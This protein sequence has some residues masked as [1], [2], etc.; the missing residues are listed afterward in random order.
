MARAFLG[1]IDVLIERAGFNLVG[2]EKVVA[3]VHH[4]VGRRSLFRFFFL[5]A[6]DA[7]GERREIGLVDFGEFAFIVFGKEFFAD[8]VDNVVF[9]PRGELRHGHHHAVAFGDGLPHAV[10][11]LAVFEFPLVEF[12]GDGNGAFLFDV[13]VTGDAELL[14]DFLTAIEGVFSPVGDE[15]FV[16]GNFERLNP[17]LV[18]S[19]AGSFG[20][21]DCGGIAGV[22]GGGEQLPLGCRFGPAGLFPVE[23]RSVDLVDLFLSHQLD[24]VSG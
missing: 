18:E 14:V 22:S 17:S 1:D 8:V 4:F 16:V 15:G 5:N 10:R 11:V 20:H 3:E 7:A 21:G 9:L 19:E 2:P 24:L 23:V 6:G 12:Q 13:T